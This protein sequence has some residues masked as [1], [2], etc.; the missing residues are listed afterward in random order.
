[1]A[2]IPFLIISSNEHKI[3]TRKTL[4]SL[5]EVFCYRIL[6]TQYSFKTG[7]M[8]P[9]FDRFDAQVNF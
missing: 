6:G 2:L 1:M 9:T 5:P 3:L 7:G 8:R 4:A